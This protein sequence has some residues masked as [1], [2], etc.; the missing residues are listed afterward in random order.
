MRWGQGLLALGV[1][2]G[3]WRAYQMQRQ[4]QATRIREQRLTHLL[5]QASDGH[6]ELDAQFRL[7]AVHARRANEHTRADP[8]HLGRLLWDHPR[9]SWDAETLDQLR[10]HLELHEPFRDL[11]V[12]ALGNRAQAYHL[13]VSGAPRFSTN[14]QFLG[15][16]GVARDVS[17]EQQ[18]R[19]ALQASEAR[20]REL[21]ALSP[22]ALV[23]HRQGR[24]VGANPAAL[25]LLGRSSLQALQET[26]LIEFFEGDIQP[27]QALAW[28][29]P[30]PRSSGG[31]AA[32]PPHTTLTDL[33]LLVA[34]RRVWVRSAG[35]AVNSERGPA[36]MTLLIDDT[37]RRAAEEAVRR[38]E[39]L[40]SLVFATSPDLITL[41]ELA[42]GRYQ[43]V[44]RSFER[45]MG[46]TAQEA[47]GRSALELGI[48]PTAQARRQFVR[49]VLDQR[50]VS[51][52]AMTFVNKAGKPVPLRVSAAR[53]TNEQHDYIVI[54]ARDISA[55][56]RERLERE[57]ILANASVGIVLIRERRFVLVNRHFESLVGWPAG[58][59]L[60]QAQNTVWPEEAQR[61]AQATGQHETELQR[62]DG[63]RFLARIRAHPI[64]PHNPEEGGR[65]CIVEDITEQRRFE[66]T[67]QRARAEA[68]ASSRAKSAFLA[69][70]SH[71]LRTPL[72]AITG[73]AA[74]ACEPQTD[75]PTRRAYLNQ[76]TASVNAL[77]ATVTGI[78][79]LSQLTAGQV[80]IQ[81]RAFDLQRLLDALHEAFAPAALAKGLELHSDTDHSA[82]RV[83]GDA[84]RL[85]QVLQHLLSNAIKFTSRGEITLRAVRKATS[86]WMRFE[87][88]DTGPGIAEAARESMFQ[89]FSQAD[90]SHTRQH[91]GTGLGLPTCRELVKL[92]GG[93]M[94]MQDAL[95]GQTD[96]GSLFWVELPLPVAT[97]AEAA[98]SEQAGPTAAAGPQAIVRDKQ[99]PGQG[100]IQT[101]GRSLQGL[102]VLMVDDNE[103]NRLVASAT[104][105]QWGV[106][107][108]QRVDGAQAVEAVEAAA[109]A[110]PGQPPGPAFDAILMDLQ[111]PVMSGFDA[112][113][114]IRARPDSQSVPIIALTAAALESER[115]QA[116]AAGMNDFISKP[117]DAQRLHAALLY[118]CGRP[119]PGQSLPV[120]PSPGGHSL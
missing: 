65:V 17:A 68:E 106:V 16:W 4:L 50:V 53:F 108:V 55:S 44:N 29:A 79:D 61:A 72:N 23:L 102:R 49:A 58:A 96:R 38:S 118:W 112:T 90:V 28:L 9:L 103:V 78:L 63:S 8:H 57:V 74:L 66:Q 93:H 109:H 43:M 94:G 45:L 59:L 113:R 115:A 13:L 69:N 101:S 14:G 19:A 97:L 88:L 56:E 39:A 25:Q 24:V 36:V 89:P 51:E 107:V 86:D 83:C 95:P 32:S 15:Y 67:L 7:V 92:M 70:T 114:A 20:Y 76:L 52:M 64:D 84:V 111:M 26:N 85:Q 27:E 33:R 119:A 75:E 98:T 73:L 60:G 11:A 105:E 47:L 46:W 5:Q 42:S 117:I 82:G 87:V 3:A 10:A 2:L 48:W 116:L 80:Q 71:E 62:R 1:L 40:L 35:V 30:T 41:S 54:N 100:R 37:E 110:L 99:N 6:W 21:F 91:G 22:T 104:L 12:Q 18:T 77:A 120:Q 31:L 81:S 34:G